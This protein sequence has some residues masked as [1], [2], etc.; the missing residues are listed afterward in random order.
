MNNFTKKQLAFLAL[1]TCLAGLL[2]MIGCSCQNS[3]EQPNE[4]SPIFQNAVATLYA[5]VPPSSSSPISRSDITE[6]PVNA[7]IST[8]IDKFGLEPT[9]QTLPSLFYSAAEGGDYVFLFLPTNEVPSPK[10]DSSSD[11]LPLIA[12]V[13]VDNRDDLKAGKGIY[14]LP[15]TVAGKTFT[16]FKEN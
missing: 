4:M 9:S 11:D 3:Q 12:V 14:V 7:T 2:V 1:I 15:K 8:V 13:K 5:T 6:L 16:G 10:S